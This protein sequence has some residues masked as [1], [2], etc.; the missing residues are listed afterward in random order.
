MTTSEEAICSAPWLKS[1]IVPTG[2]KWGNQIVD[3]TVAGLPKNLIGLPLLIPESPDEILFVTHRW[4]RKASLGW[5]AFLIILAFPDGSRYEVEIPAS[6]K[7]EDGH[8]YRIPISTANTVLRERPKQMGRSIPRIVYNLSAPLVK[9]QSEAIRSSIE[10]V[11][12]IADLIHCSAS[13]YLIIED[14]AGLKEVENSGIPNFLEAYQALRPGSYKADLLR[15]Y[16]LYKYGGVYLDDKSIMRAPLDSDI[17]DSIFVSSKGESCDLFICVN[18]GTPEIAFMGS[19]RGSPIMLLALEMGISNVI[20]R[21]YGHDRL[22]ITGN[23]MF[24]QIVDSGIAPETQ[25]EPT[26]QDAATLLRGAKCWG[27]TVTFLSMAKSNEAII[28]DNN[29]VWYRQAVAASDWPKL[30]TYY[31]DLWGHRS[32]F[33]DGNAVPNPL[34]MVICSDNSRAVLVALLFSTLFCTVGYI[35]SRFPPI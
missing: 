35:L 8:S 12:E 16:L 5:D 29:I 6:V 4:D 30:S 23:T 22:S 15:Y 10:N 27:E 19:R 31:W 3:V 17:M 1:S 32:V 18:R 26:P 20:K 25:E 21:V 34:N 24:K 33:V 11:R 2:K 7:L 14:E 13:L 9:Q 28:N